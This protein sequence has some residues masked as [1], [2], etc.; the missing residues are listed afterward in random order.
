KP[1]DFSVSSAVYDN[2]GGFWTITVRRNNGNDIRIYK[3]AGD[4]VT[5]TDI[6]ESTIIATTAASTTTAKA[7]STTTAAATKAAAKSTSKNSSPKTGVAFPAIPV[8][9]LAIAAVAVAF[10]LKKKEN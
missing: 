7:Q 1:E 10:T 3:V 6:D 5:R 4:T 2:A 8:A 9:G